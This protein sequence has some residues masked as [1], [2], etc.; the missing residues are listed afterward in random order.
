MAR[1]YVGT[2]AKY[3]AGNLAGS[4]LD[5]E[6]YADKDE[7]L[8]ACQELHADESDPELMFQD[9][10]DI[11]ESLYSESAISSQIWDWLELDEDE[12]IIADIYAD[13][14][15]KFDIDKAR[16]CF[17]GKADSLEDWC[18]E[19]L[20]ETGLLNQIPDNLR[21][22]FDYAAYARD[23][24][25]GGDVWTSRKGGFIYVFWNQ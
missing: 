22:Y 6:D 16:D 17:A 10:E 15:V 9:Y 23:L 24:E 12:R 18:A 25:L 14:C 8:A 19:F 13:V 7:F 20:E 5:L 3:N 4:W 1:L 2:Y 11:P 21:Y